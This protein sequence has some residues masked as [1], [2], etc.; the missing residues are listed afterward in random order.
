MCCFSKYGAGKLETLVSSSCPTLFQLH[1]LF[2][3][4]FVTGF[5]ITL[6]ETCSAWW[7][8][9]NDQK[10][11]EGFGR[12]LHV[13]VPKLLLLYTSELRD[14]LVWKRCFYTWLLASSFWVSRAENEEGTFSWSWSEGRGTEMPDMEPGGEVEEMKAAAGLFTLWTASL[15]HQQ[16]A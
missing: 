8:N 13:L 12:F 3:K 15:T 1:A 2:C 7:L 6:C 16:L 14:A 4:Q 9:Q 10:G 11:F 5:L